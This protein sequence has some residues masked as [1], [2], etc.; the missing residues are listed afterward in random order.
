[1]TYRYYNVRREINND[2]SEKEL[3]KYRSFEE[4]KKLYKPFHWVVFSLMFLSLFGVLSGAG[5]GVD[6]IAVLHDR[7][8]NV[9]EDGDARQR[10][11][12]ERPDGAGESGGEGHTAQAEDDDEVAADDKGVVTS[13]DGAL[14]VG[15]P[16]VGHIALGRHLLYGATYIIIGIIELTGYERSVE[17]KDE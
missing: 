14:R 12:N 9:A 6:D 7:V 1:M 15:R 11:D 5:S 4:L 10:E 3:N 16:P 13:E 8:E 17:E 2:S